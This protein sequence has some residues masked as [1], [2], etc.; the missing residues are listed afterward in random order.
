[1]VLSFLPWLLNS[2]F[3]PP[4]FF[5]AGLDR[6]AQHVLMRAPVPRTA[7]AQHHKEKGEN[8]GL[9]DPTAA[10]EQQFDHQEPERWQERKTV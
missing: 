3:L 7:Q 8:E 9:E 2:W 5:D 1:M 4:I 10:A 6:L